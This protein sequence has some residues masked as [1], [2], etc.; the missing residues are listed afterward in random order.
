MLHD[1][2][3][4]LFQTITGSPLSF[5]EWEWAVGMVMSRALASPAGWA[6]IPVADMMDFAYPT[7]TVLSRLTPTA[8]E[9]YAAVDLAPGDVVRYYFCFCF[10]FAEFAEFAV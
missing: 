10:C 6:L 1:V 7:P 3:K 4:E 8:V 5:E 9:Y 2:M